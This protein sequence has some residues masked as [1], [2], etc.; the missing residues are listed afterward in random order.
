MLDSIQNE[1]RFLIIKSN[2]IKIFISPAAIEALY[3][4]VTGSAF[5]T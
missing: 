2:Q 3:I 4:S 1:F 5:Y